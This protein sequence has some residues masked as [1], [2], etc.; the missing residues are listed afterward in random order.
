MQTASAFGQVQ[1]A[2]SYIISA[3][4]DIAEMWSV[5]SRLEGFIAGMQKADAM[6]AASG[7]ATTTAQDLRV[8]GLSLDL[9]DARPLLTMPA[10]HVA[11]GDS[12][13][14]RGDRK[15]TRLNSSH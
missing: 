2:L 3:Y 6:R 10:L 14:I 4:T 1:S 11:A 8:D 5:V 9:P 15:S 7:I 12:L 13:P